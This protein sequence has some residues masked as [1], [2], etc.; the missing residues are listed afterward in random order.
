[1]ER[2]I[3]TIDYTMNAFD[4]PDSTQPMYNLYEYIG[5]L[6]KAITENG[7]PTIFSVH[8]VDKNDPQKE[9]LNVKI[10]LL[11]LNFDMGK[12]E[13]IDKFVKLADDR[14]AVKNYRRTKS[15][16]PLTSIVRITS[17]LSHFVRGQ[18]A[19]RHCLAQGD[20]ETQYQLRQL[21][22]S[23]SHHLSIYDAVVEEV[24]K[25]GENLNCTFRRNPNFALADHFNYISTFMQKRAIASEYRE[26]LEKHQ[27][28]IKKYNKVGEAL[29]AYKNQETAESQPSSN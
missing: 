4:Y 22:G 8:I 20:E 18:I 25:D 17:E 3:E 10:P 19:L 5:M 1:M 21:I 7:V 6:L 12:Q 28:V 15:S 11:P 2:E 26:T 13:E 29:E 14:E 9:I 27:R 23:P 24:F 16:K